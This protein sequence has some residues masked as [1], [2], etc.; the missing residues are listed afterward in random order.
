MN[1]KKSKIKNWKCGVCGYERSAATPP[2]SCPQCS[3]GSGEF[4]ERKEKTKLRYDGKKYDVLLINGSIHKTHN[5]G[6]ICDMAEVELRKKKISYLRINLSEYNIM[7]CWCCY[8]MADFACTYPCRNQLDDAPAL[9]EH[10]INSKAVIVA[11]PINWNNMTVTLK[12]FLDRLTSIQN[13]TLLG[14]TSLTVNKTFG[15]IINGHEDGAMKTAMDIFFYFEQLG[16]I[17]APFGIGYKTHGA[18]N[19]AETDND[20]FKN[21]ESLKKQIRGVVNNVSEMI[22]LDLEKKL[23][24]KIK[25]VAE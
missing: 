2:E 4:F 11:S 25:P 23:K 21:N 10:I 1:E 16:Y 7:G 12:K 3:S 24:D 17:M 8:S 15:I 5:T 20:F 6:K 18:E 22:K 9:H 19:K 13:R 14:K